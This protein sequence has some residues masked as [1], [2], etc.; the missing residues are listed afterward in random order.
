MIIELA[1]GAGIVLIGAVALRLVGRRGA[2][3]PATAEA[4]A[5][6]E[7]AR[8]QQPS[9]PP[10]GLEPA[11]EEHSRK[12]GRD[13]SPRGLRVGDVLLY[14]ETEIWLAG[15]VYLDEEGFALSLFAAPGARSVDF[16]AQLDA[17]ASEVSFVART[18]DV[19]DGSVPTEL[20]IAGVRLSLRRR[21]RALVTTAGEHLPLV[22]ERASYAL[23]G[24]PGGRVLL[25]VDF[26]GGERL[27]LVGNRVGR[28]MY[29][30]LP[31]GDLEP[32]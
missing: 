4:Q 15:E 29:D 18:S 24:G 32:S 19:P 11:P 21:G 30:L 13:A 20:P 5:R 16:V 27:A 10:P 3:A 8:A 2:T 9:E 26:E 25:V 12:P 1:V 14:M 28:E 31:G 23:L 6:P 17:D 22:T 7:T